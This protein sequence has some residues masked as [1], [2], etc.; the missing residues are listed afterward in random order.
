MQIQK[1]NIKKSKLTHHVRWTNIY[2]I[3]QVGQ[4]NLGKGET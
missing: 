3:L 4:G 1:Q 2:G